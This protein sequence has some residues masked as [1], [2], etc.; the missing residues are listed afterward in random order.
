[1]GAQED[2][3]PRLP[4]DELTPAQRAAAARTP[5]PPGAAPLPAREVER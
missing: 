4:D 1:M 2:R 5:P 3:L